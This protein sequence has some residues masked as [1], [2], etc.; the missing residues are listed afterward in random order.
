MSNIPS[1]LRYSAEHEWVD[2]SSPVKVGL[3]AVA[4]DALG[5]VVYLDLPEAGSTVTAGEVCGE[6][7]STKSVSELFAPVSGTVVDVNAA[8]VD[9]PGLVNSDP[10]GDGWLFT[11]EVTDEGELLTAEQYEQAQEDQA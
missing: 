8:V 4:V 11:V 7:E 1:H 5:D 10:Y 9:E 2:E 3:S 6:V